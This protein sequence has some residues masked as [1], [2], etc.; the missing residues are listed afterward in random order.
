MS[1]FHKW[2]KP[3]R[4]RV[5]HVSAGPEKRHLTKCGRVILNPEAYEGPWGCSSKP[6]CV[7]C[8]NNIAKDAS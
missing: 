5:A 7:R 4:Y 2:F 6:R 3:R 8:N 1:G